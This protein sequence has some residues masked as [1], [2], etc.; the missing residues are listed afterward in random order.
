MKNI[1]TL[2]LFILSGFFF[3]AMAA[4]DTLK[5]KTSA[6]CK[7][8]KERIETRLSFTKGIKSAA[9]D[10]KTKE[11]TVIYNSEKIK[12]EEIKTAITRSGYDADNLPADK[13]AYDKLPKCCKKGGPE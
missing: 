5:V 1:T 8:C 10:L 7:E 12:P 6:I 2:L 9:L 11:V 13:K 3:S 4:T